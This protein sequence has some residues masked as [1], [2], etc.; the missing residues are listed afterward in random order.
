MYSNTDKYI[1]FNKQKNNSNVGFIIN[2]GNM[3]TYILMYMY[4]FMCLKYVI[5]L[6]MKIYKYIHTST[7]IY[8]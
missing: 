8:T 4:T 1:H 6:Y 7:G 3:H 2:L 5:S